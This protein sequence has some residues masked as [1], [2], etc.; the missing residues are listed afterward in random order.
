MDLLN[1]EKLAL[2]P[3][4]SFGAPGCVRLSYATSQEELQVAMEKLCS[5]RQIRDPEEDKDLR[6]FYAHNNS[7]WL[8][9]GPMKVEVRNKKPYLAVL[10]GLLYDHECDKITKF[11][12]PTLNFPPGRMSGKKRN[13][14][15]M[16][17]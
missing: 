1:E 2:V 17:K 7:P 9:L 12:G 3:G 6:S 15:T 14:W 13:D 10:R 11:L 16:K 5:G 4:S 8:R